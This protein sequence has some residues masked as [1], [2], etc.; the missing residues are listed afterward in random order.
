[1]KLGG[2]RTALRIAMREMRRAK[3]RSALVVAMIALPVLALSFTAVTYDMF[4]LTQ[5]EERD[6]R[7]GPADAELQ[8]YGD[9][10]VR[11]DAAGTSWRVDGAGSAS[12]SSADQADPPTEAELLT[13]LPPG[14]RL[15]TGTLSSGLTLGGPDDVIQIE[16]RELD[17][18]DPLHQHLMR[19]VRG[20]AP[21]APN[22]A[23]ASERALRRLGVTIGGTIRPLDG[24]SPY[25]VVGVVELAD[26]LGEVLVVPPLPKPGQP[27][28][29]WLLDV[30]GDLTWELVERLNA[31][32]VLVT[33]RPVPDAPPAPADTEGSLVRSDPETLSLGV[34]IGGLGL[35]EVVLLAGPALAVGA[36]RRRRDL[37]LV[38]A[39]GGPAAALRRIVLADGVLLGGCGALV[40]LALGVTAAIAGRPL[41]EEFVFLHRAGAIR[42]FPAALVAIAGLAVVAGVLAALVPAFVAA[43]QDVVAG[44]SGRPGRRGSRRRWLV[45]GV[46]LTGSGAALAATGADA[47]QATVILSGLILAEIGLVIC[48]PSLIG[49]L[50]RIGRQLPLAP[51]IALR[52]T[53]RNR[54]SAAPAI[55]AVMAAVASSVALG[56]F[57]NGAEARQQAAMEPTVPSSH[58]WVE[59]LVPPRPT[60]PLSEDRVAAIAGAHFTLDGLTELSTPACLGSTPGIDDDTGP[61]PASYCAV[62]L[63]LPAE[64]ECPYVAGDLSEPE[65]LRA[66]EDPRCE[67]VGRVQP[68]P[69]L[70]DTVLVDD[71]PGL[72][73]LTGAEAGDLAGAT[74]M[75]RDGGVVVNDPHLV[76]GGTVTMEVY[77]VTAN[78]TERTTV[79]QLPA[80]VLTS[81]FES[82]RQIVSAPTLSRLG[83]A[84]EPSG[85]L[86]ATTGAPTD[87]ELKAFENDLRTVDPGAIVPNGDGWRTD[88]APLLLLLAGV[89]ALV[90][91]GAAGM[92]TGLAAAQG[93]ADLSTLA[94]IGASP[95]VRRVLSLSQAGIIAGVGSLLGLIAGLTVAFAII[96]ALN[97]AYA[98][99]WPVED[100]YPVLMPW[101]ILGI[102]LVV[103]IVTMLGAGL[104][105]P[106]RLPIERRIH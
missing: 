30:P 96:T 81:G 100:P 18:G 17:F 70:I 34:L 37:A 15:A 64:Q 84:S 41:A 19:L 9:G 72:P 77:Q 66:R 5:A 94:A 38:A 7:L 53:A 79:Q 21:A 97:R 50:A 57:A 13:H 27:T 82:S 23:A 86:V 10:P 105:T 55:S 59:Y 60:P 87:G 104:L 22:E 4:R 3:G 99:T 85:F 98:R 2:W 39:N 76:S 24:T 73:T 101:E 78:G 42:I 91:I 36:L 102:L 52:D 14:S 32:G 16:S 11:Q 93:R 90:T 63:R 62:S 29:S 44:L 6:R 61:D 65:R 35:L 40:G 88:Y 75:L 12:G 95:G 80:Y 49:L 106:S 103:P 51:R 1:M 54:A 25:T 58:V 20:R 67:S 74:A 46:V 31:V 8:W 43:R 69:P 68:G 92:A 71:G 45:T 33:A 28:T 47:V 83:L 48:T 89:A 26:T 56:V